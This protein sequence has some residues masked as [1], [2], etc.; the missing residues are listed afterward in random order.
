[1]FELTRV[2]MIQILSE[3]TQ[4]PKNKLVVL[5]NAVL[6]QM[7]LEISKPV[8][9]KKS[10]RTCVICKCEKDLSEF[11]P[12]HRQVACKGTCLAEYSRMARARRKARLELTI[13]PVRTAP[14]FDLTSYLPTLA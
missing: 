10:T 13:E 9:V 1:M 3:K 2:E 8:R 11:G 4:T 7:I 12:T 6:E 14:S 5:K